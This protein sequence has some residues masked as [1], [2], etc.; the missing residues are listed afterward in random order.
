MYG[1]MGGDDWRICGMVRGGCRMKELLS[2][3][4]LFMEG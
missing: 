3:R 1:E 4:S 2:G